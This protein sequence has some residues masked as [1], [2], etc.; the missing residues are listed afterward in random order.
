MNAI[1][2][3]SFR[4]H[5]V[6]V[7]TKL[8]SLF[9]YTHY[10]DNGH[11]PK[12]VCHYDEEMLTLECVDLFKL[13]PNVQSKPRNRVDIYMP[14]EAALKLGVQIISL[15]GKG[16]IAALSNIDPNLFRKGPQTLPRIDESRRVRHKYSEMIIA[17][18]KVVGESG[19]VYVDIERPSEGHIEMKG[20]EVHIGVPLSSVDGNLNKDL[21]ELVTIPETELRVE[22]EKN[23]VK[24]S[25]GQ[26][27][28]CF[29][30]AEARNL[31]TTLLNFGQRIQ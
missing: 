3:T 20:P 21:I 25:M 12:L 15:Y 26:L 28:I 6:K 2:E 10:A 16:E 4:L 5:V 18:F 13:K 29:E 30:I 11:D 14:G 27:R 31:A 7:P 19:P 8:R 17:G 22:G 24:K 9:P 23:P 1:T